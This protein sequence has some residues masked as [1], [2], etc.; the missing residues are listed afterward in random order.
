[1]SKPP[2]TVWANWKPTTTDPLKY[3]AFIHHVAFRSVLGGLVSQ[4]KAGEFTGMI[5]QSWHVSQDQLQWTFRIRDGY[6]FENGNLITP[7]TVVRSWTRLA[8]LLNKKRSH[9]DLFDAIPDLASASSPRA[10]I[11]GL[12]AKGDDLIIKLK[13]PFPNLLETVAFGLYAI[14]DDADYD[15]TSGEWKDPYHLTSANAY[16]I[17]TWNENQLN[18]ELREDF[19][20]SLLHPQPVH[21][22]SLKWDPKARS[23]AEII[24]G[25]SNASDLP[26]QEY[27]FYGGVHSGIAYAHCYNWN[28][29]N[30]ICSNIN[31]RR[32]LRDLLHASLEKSGIKPIRS[33]FPL[34]MQGISEI[35]ET[36]EA[37]GQDALP[38]F[39]FYLRRKFGNSIFDAIKTHLPALSAEFR[40]VANEREL[41]LEEL[42]AALDPH[43]GSAAVDVG[44]MATGILIEDPRADIRFM[45][46]TKEG[47]RLPDPDGKLA[48]EVR[49]P[50][51]SAQKI[52]QMLWDQAIIIPLGHFA[53]GVWAKNTLDFSL[54]NQVQPPIEFNWIGHTD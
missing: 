44:I 10:F 47:I 50:D 41:Q 45:I 19:P 54:L 30:S 24:V 31:Q 2:I 38:H 53:S 17:D 20:K 11:S 1:M 22:I 35:R 40:A 32:K 21:S 5:A 18:L 51:F 48:E 15:P 13:R 26:T 12:E 6:R 46:L 34:G 29:Q 52:N 8:Y 49:K 25:D 43:K 42:F 27:T 9:S 14:I 3:D 36:D 28:K 4:Y 7:E 39:G 37:S 16:R 33:F 23:E